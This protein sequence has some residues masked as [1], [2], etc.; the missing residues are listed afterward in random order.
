M[1]AMPPR[2]GLSGW[3]KAEPRQGYVQVT[4]PVDRDELHPD[5]SKD[6]IRALHRRLVARAWAGGLRTVSGISE[7]VAI[8]A[9]NVSRWLDD[10]GLV[11]EDDPCEST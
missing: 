9:W 1:T 3:K 2:T 5:T 8:P 4:F 7:D 11:P 10:L 6:V